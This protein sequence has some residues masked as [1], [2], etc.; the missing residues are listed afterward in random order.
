M[1]FIKLSDAEIIARPHFQRF[2]SIVRAAWADWMA[3]A[4]ASQ[5]QHK[6]VRANYVWNQLL[7]NAKRQFEGVQGIRVETLKNWDGVLVQDRIFIR[8][9]KGTHDLLS[10]NYPTQ[11]S[12]AFH[13]TTQDL[14]G[15]IA[16]L[17]LL[18]VLNK[19]ETAIERIALVQRH[20][21]S[22]AW[23]IDLLDDAAA[24]SA[25]TVMPFTPPQLPGSVAERLINPKEGK[26]TDGKRE[27]K[28]GS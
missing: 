8:M 14:F 13:D 6:R 7:A 11:A 23:F 16:R 10:R 2:V 26:K 25:Q 20:R 28:R 24:A 1:S 15:G 19:A 9:K 22:V 17:E 5:M 18:Y 12:L 21:S 4:I 27:P 3:G